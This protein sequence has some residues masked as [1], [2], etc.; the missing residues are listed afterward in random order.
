MISVALGELRCPSLIYVYRM[1]WAE[2]NL[3]LISFDRE[4]KRN[5]HLARNIAWSAYIAPHQDPKKLRGMRIDK[6][7][8]TDKKKV[9]VTDEHRNRF[10]EEYKKYL[11]KVNHART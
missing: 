4:Q 2:F 9:K 8:P 1:T 3:R 6:W 7:W 11:E 10:L 5:E